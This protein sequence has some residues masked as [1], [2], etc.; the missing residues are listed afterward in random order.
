M[1]IIYPLENKFDSLVNKNIIYNKLL[2]L[3]VI[4]LW[5]LFYFF[6]SNPAV[7]N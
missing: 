1:Y 2:I 4:Q 5:K 7:I 3:L 6:S